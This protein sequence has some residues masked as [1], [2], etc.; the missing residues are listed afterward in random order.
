MDKVFTHST[1]NVR[2]VLKR[3]YIG[4]DSCA[5]LASILHHLISKEAQRGQSSPSHSLQFG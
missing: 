2:T 4:Q 3:M 5:Q 1:V